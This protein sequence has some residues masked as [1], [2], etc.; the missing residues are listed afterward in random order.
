MNPSIRDILDE[1]ADKAGWTL[2]E[3][4]VVACAFIDAQRS[5]WAFREFAEKQCKAATQEEEEITLVDIA[6]PKEQP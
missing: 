1:L 5:P 4:L 2:E 6:P 3:M